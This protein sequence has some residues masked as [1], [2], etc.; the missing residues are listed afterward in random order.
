[1]RA[2]HNYVAKYN[3]DTEFNRNIISTLDKKFRS[4]DTNG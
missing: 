1:M 4:V 3:L 2:P